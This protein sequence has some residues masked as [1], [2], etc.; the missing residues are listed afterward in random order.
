MMSLS[1]S[2]Y[3]FA[4]LFLYMCEKETAKEVAVLIFGYLSM[5]MNMFL[6]SAIFNTRTQTIAYISA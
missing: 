1:V 6:F 5:M 4:D 3:L 2:L